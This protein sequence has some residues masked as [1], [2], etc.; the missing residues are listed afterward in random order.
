MVHTPEPGE[1]PEKFLT[2][3]SLQPG[4]VLVHRRPAVDMVWVLPLLAE[5]LPSRLGFTALNTTAH[6]V[7]SF[8]CQSQ[9]IAAFGGWGFTKWTVS[10]V[11]HG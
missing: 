11:H 6:E 8:R 1:M 4:E 5:T 9:M 2:E 10:L 3:R 7:S